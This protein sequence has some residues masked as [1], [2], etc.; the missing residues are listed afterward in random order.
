MSAVPSGRR[1]GFIGAGAI[2]LPMATRLAAAGHELCV[3]D[4]SEE[5]RELARA[6]G[7]AASQ[8]MAALAGQRTRHRGRG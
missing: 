4:P 7:M 2:G 8:Q 6:A 1:L 5:R 3:V